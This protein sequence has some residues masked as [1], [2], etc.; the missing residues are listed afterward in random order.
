MALYQKKWWKKLFRAG[1]K[2]EK[3]QQEKG[4]I[5]PLKNVQAIIEYLKE[6]SVD[7]R[8]LIPDLQKLEELEKEREVATEG[9]LQ[10]NLDAQA[11]LLDGILERYEFL[12]ND[13]DIN[14]IRVKQIASRLLEQAQQAG[15]HDLISEK[16]KDMR[17]KFNW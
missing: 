2:E 10:V 14:G 15:M 17:W 8:R 12:Q 9:L 16:K 5:M 13:A 6:I 3:E 4:K 11:K 7:S 1:K